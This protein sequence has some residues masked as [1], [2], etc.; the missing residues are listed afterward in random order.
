MYKLLKKYYL[1]GLYTKDDLRKYVEHGTITQAE[2]EQIIE[3]V[4]KIIAE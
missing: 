2:M 1:K 3:E 4:E